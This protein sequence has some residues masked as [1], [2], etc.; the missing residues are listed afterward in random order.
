MRGMKNTL[1][2]VVVAA[3]AL[4]TSCGKQ[5]EPAKPAAAETPA[6]P[7]PA[8]RVG[9]SCSQDCGKGV[10]AA[11]VCAEGETPQCACLPAPVAKCLVPA[12]AKP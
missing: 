8:A 6:S 7:P 5:P 11:I 3:C 2:I 12:A 9:Q 10:K 4:F 1:L